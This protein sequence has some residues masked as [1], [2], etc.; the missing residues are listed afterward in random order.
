MNGKKG[1]PRTIH[2]NNSN[3]EIKIALRKWLI[4][5]IDICSVLDVYGGHGLMYD[6]VW[7]T[8]EY[9]FTKNDSL[10]WLGM[11]KG[12]IHDCFDIDPYSSPFEAM[13]I[14]CKKAIKGRI[15]IVCTDGFLRRQAGMRG[16]FTKF[17]QEKCNWPAKDNDLMA[18]VFHQYP[19]YLRHVINR[20]C[21]DY[22]I[23]KLAIKYGPKLQHSTVYF[24]AILILNQNKS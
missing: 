6:R 18:R 14:V 11:Q 13:E 15:G 22:E 4:G 10:K 3:P 7:K 8:F 23:E 17:I 9:S 2:K 12:L 24:A 21:G 1:G 5:N 19:S 20:I 16:N